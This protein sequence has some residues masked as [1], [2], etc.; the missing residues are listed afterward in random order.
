MLSQ[1]PHVVGSPF[2]RRIHAAGGVSSIASYPGLRFRG[3]FL[4]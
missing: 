3:R 4:G 2:C 1:R